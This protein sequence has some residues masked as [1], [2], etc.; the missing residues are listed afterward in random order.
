[1]SF[2]AAGSVFESG[3]WGDRRC[4]GAGVNREG[5]Q[6]VTLRMREASQI[7][8]FKRRS[9]TQPAGTGAGH[10]GASVTMRIN[11]GGRGPAPRNRGFVASSWAS[12]R[13]SAAMNTMYAGPAARTREIGTLRALGFSRG[14]ISRLCPGINVP[15]LDWRA[16]WLLIALP[17]NGMT[18]AAASNFADGRVRPSGSAACQWRSRWACR[19]DGHCWRSPSSLPRLPASDYL[20]IT[21]A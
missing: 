9:R 15:G 2:D 6:S 14:S 20:S 5:F 19:D 16:S 11:R 8:A 1:M 21:R 17:A 12:A 7:G 18:S 3:V 4:D 10:R 13:V